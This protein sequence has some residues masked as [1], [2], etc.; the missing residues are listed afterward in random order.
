VTGPDH[1]RHADDAGAYLLGALSELEIRAFE[2]HVAVCPECRDEIERL[3]PAAEAISRS[4]EQF[5]AP[6]SLKGSLMATVGSEARE[7]AAAADR[8]ALPSGSGWRRALSRLVL[9]P[10]RLAWAAA[11]LLL[12]GA[13]V[14]L[15]VDRATRAGSAERVLA[16]R[17]DPRALPG[18]SARLVLRDGREAMLRVSGLPVLRGGRVYEVWIQHAGS[19][20][21]AGALFEVHSDGTGTAAIPRAVGGGDSVLVTRER[22]GGAARPSE[23]PVISARV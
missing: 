1:E 22:A 7:R 15:G 12:V 11:A 23:A 13:A 3:R 2:R 8:G 21:P 20:R 19:V 18:G 6:A 10:T 5:E 4:P 17:V 16:A 14:G 9:P